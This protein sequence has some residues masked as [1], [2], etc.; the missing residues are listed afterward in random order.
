M[1]AS[2]ALWFIKFKKYY[3]IAHCCFCFL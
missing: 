2:L 1:K 3:N